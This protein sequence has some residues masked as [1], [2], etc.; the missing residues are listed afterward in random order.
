MSR[1]GQVRGP[2]VID[3]PSALTPQDSSESD[4]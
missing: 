4:A 2:K 1:E 3:F